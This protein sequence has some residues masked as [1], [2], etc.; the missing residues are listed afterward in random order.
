M[1]SDIMN[2][3]LPRCSELGFSSHTGLNLAHGKIATLQGDTACADA[4]PYLIA[5]HIRTF[6]TQN[7]S[8][9]YQRT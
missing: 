6:A 1:P 5:L 9:V 3:I 7:A 8:A 4:A 2:C